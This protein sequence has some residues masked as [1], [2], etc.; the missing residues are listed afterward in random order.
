[1]A[2]EGESVQLKVHPVVEHDDSESTPDYQA[3]AWIVRTIH[4]K[5]L[6]QAY[7]F[8][9]IVMLLVSTFLITWVSIRSFCL[10][11]LQHCRL[12]FVQMLL[13]HHSGEWWVITLEVLVTLVIVLEVA[14]KMCAFGKNFW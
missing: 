6:S 10:V 13:G 9:C 11:Y 2:E 3:D 8:L 1:M 4:N 12:S 14:A 5:N 7:Y